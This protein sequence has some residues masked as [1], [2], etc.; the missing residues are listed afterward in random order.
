MSNLLL[1]YFFETEEAEGFMPIYTRNSITDELHSIFDF[2]TDYRII[3]KKSMN[4]IISYTKNSRSSQRKRA[5][6][7]E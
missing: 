2:R 6:L 3:T 1:N 5:K 7:K 4:E